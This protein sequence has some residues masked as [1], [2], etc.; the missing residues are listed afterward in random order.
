MLM[1]PDSFDW[2][3]LDGEEEQTQLGDARRPQGA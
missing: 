3:S 2:L 1:D